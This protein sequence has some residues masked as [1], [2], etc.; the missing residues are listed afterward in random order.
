MVKTIFLFWSGN[1]AVC[2]EHGR[3]VPELQGHY[4]DVVERLRLEDLSR[5][6]ISVDESF[7]PGGS[8]G[9]VTPEEF[10]TLEVKR[11]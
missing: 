6:D 3:Q 8:A 11:L 1:V 9:G 4:L 5:A 7:L 2:D 10:L